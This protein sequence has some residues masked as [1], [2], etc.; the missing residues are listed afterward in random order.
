[1]GWDGLVHW[2]WSGDG[3]MNVDM[4]YERAE[5][6]GVH[7]GYELDKQ[8]LEHLIILYFWGFQPSSCAAFQ[9]SCCLLRWVETASF[10]CHHAARCQVVRFVE[11]EE[12]GNLKMRCA[13]EE[14]E[15]E[16]EKVPRSSQVRRCLGLI[17]ARRFW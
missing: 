2:D 7:L 8:S 10:R 16:F 17:A 1:M 6:L 4:I 9:I 15:A 11:R 5:S 3:D 14:Q 13:T 12:T